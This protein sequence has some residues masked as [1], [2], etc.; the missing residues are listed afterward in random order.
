[1]KKVDIRGSIFGELPFVESEK[2]EIVRAGEKRF[3]RIRGIRHI[4]DYSDDK[5]GLAMKKGR[6]L[7]EGQ[8]LTCITYAGGAIGIEGRITRVSFLEDRK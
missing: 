3:I 7:I 4:L 2:I 8:G 5:I 1:M 6:L